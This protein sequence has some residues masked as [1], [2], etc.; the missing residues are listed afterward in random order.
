[1]EIL[2]KNKGLST[3]FEVRT[4]CSPGSESYEE[5]ML[6]SNCLTSLAP[7]QSQWV[8]GKRLLL[9]KTD[10][11]V[12]IARKWG[13]VGPGWPEVMQ[14]FL[15]I[16]AAIRELQDYLLPPEGLVFSLPYILFD[17]AAENCRFLYVPGW[18]QEQGI[19]FSEMMKHLCEEILPGL[20]FGS[21]AETMHFYDLYG[22]FLED[23]VTPELFLQITDGWPVSGGKQ[24][25]WGTGGRASSRPD[26]GTGYDEPGMGVPGMGVS[27]M[28]VPVDR[29]GPS[30]AEL[31]R[32]SEE[33]RWGLQGG[34]GR[35][36][37]SGSGER[38]RIGEGSGS[39]ER[40]RSDEGSRIGERSRIGEGSRTGEGSRG[41]EDGRRSKDPAWEGFI[42]GRG[43][44]SGFPGG[45]AILYSI[46]AGLL[47]IAGVLYL[48]FG[49]ASLRVSA[50]LAGAF[51]V[52]LI[53]RRILA[54]EMPPPEAAKEGEKE[55]EAIEPAVMEPAAK[56]PA[57][58]SEELYAGSKVHAAAYGNWAV[59]ELV[60]ADQTPP[61]FCPPVP[62]TS[63]LRGNIRQLVPVE[64]G[65]RA[66]LYVS[67]GYCRI[68]RSETENEYCIPSP[69]ISRNH[70]RLECSG[71][72]VTLQDLGSTN[73]T[74]VN[75]VRL[76]AAAAE[77]L[78]YGDV[79][80]FAGEEYYVV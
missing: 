41:G 27:G 30:R 36:T 62:A 1:M 35:S 32:K 31:I 5:K 26:P 56:E 55:A 21:E 75:H 43:R 42:A 71:N 58:A 70:A 68:G 24:E 64:V 46:G 29:R 45:N 25:G 67:E 77:E 44:G 22:R 11:M 6:C 74:F 60:S 9:Y 33:S 12:S 57:A 69:S 76:A 4:D 54:D 50:L 3:Y 16:A 19:S 40:S 17:A 61:A 28:G 52:F 14:L 39:G 49:G 80:S 79:V 18:G 15:E 7:L 20:Y 63:I 65:V 2:R 48:L 72:V 51:V 34:S 23:S 8:D 10:G 37:G 66:P 47:L 73:G 78:H 38:S 53:C 59:P 13:V